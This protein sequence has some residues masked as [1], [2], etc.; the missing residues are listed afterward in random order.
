MLFYSSIPNFFAAGCKIMQQYVT[1]LYIMKS[2]E[3]YGRIFAALSP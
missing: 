1:N 3:I 2:A